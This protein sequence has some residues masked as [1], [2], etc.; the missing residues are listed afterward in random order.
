[1][2]MSLGMSMVMMIILV[3]KNTAMT[4]ATVNLVS[5]TNKAKQ[6]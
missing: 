3:I 6:N 2:I 1:M 4:I 5:S